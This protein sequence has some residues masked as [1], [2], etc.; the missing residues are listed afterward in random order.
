MHFSF[1]ANIILQD[2]SLCLVQPYNNRDNKVDAQQEGSSI[3]S[4]S[5]L[6]EGIF[7]GY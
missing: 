6:N 5:I 3:S 2:Q 7:T 4:K 1:N